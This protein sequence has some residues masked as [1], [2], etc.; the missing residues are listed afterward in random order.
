MSKSLLVVIPKF[1][2]D[3]AGLICELEAKITSHEGF[4][5]VEELFLG[6]VD[7]SQ[8]VSEEGLNNLLPRLIKK[9]T[10]EI[11]QEIA[12]RNDEDEYFQD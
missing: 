10:N 4:W 11:K 7:I 3:K 8:I 5:Y 6:E 12:E 9:A 2:K 1:G